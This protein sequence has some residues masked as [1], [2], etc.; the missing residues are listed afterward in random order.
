MRLEDWQKWLD[1]QFVESDQTPP[2]ASMEEPAAP[3]EPAT[4]AV[5]AG[6]AGSMER[7]PE[8]RQGAVATLEPP[9]ALV[10]PVQAAPPVY[11]APIK[12]PRAAPAFLA[13]HPSVSHVEDPRIPSIEQYMPFL[14][15]REA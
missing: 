10:Q 15:N 3:V 11:A 4:A 13:A 7:E 9:P 12:T 2:A 8:A 14:R 5:S 1:T 6:T